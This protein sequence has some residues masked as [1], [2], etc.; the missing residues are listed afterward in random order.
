MRWHSVVRGRIVASCEA[1]TGDD[2][3]GLLP[4]HP[5]ALVVSDEDWRR[6]HYRRRLLR[7]GITPKS[8]EQRAADTARLNHKERIA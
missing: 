6:I 5:E 3:D 8:A 1:G 7:H 2:A 4:A